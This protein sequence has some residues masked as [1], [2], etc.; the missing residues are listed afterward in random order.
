MKIENVKL[1]DIKLNPNNP[2][3]IKDDKFKKLVQSIIDFPEMLKIRPI[4][5][6]EDMIILG[7]NMR[8]K[9]CKEAGLKEV[10]I[11]KASGLSAEKQREFL[12]K[13]NVSGGEWDWDMLADEWDYK[14]LQEWGLDIPGVSL[15]DD[16]NVSDEYNYQNK[17][18]VQFKTLEEA[19]SYHEKCIQENLKA[20]L[21]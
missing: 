18:T 7:G 8:F 20:Q 3:L 6:N 5:V 21:S 9:A 12:I 13:D 17:V 4:V 1:S 14:D 15:D 10:P 19:T 2:R 11:I 16:F